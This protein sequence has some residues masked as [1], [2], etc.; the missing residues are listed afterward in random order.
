MVSVFSCRSENRFIASAPLQHKL[1][2]NYTDASQSTT[3]KL[4]KTKMV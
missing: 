1:T 2:L 3:L 4:L